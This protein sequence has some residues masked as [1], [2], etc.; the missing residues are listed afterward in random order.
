MGEL[1]EFLEQFRAQTACPECNGA[2]L[3]A[4]ARSVRVGRLG[5]HEVVD[6]TPEAALE[7]LAG[8]DLPGRTGV[9]AENIL[10]EITARLSFLV[11][12]GLSYLQLSRRSDTLSGGEAQRIRLAAQLGSHLRGV[13]YILDEPTIGLHVR[14]NQVLLDTLRRLQHAGNSVVI[15]EHDEE[16]IRQADYVIDLG[17]GGGTQGGEV[18]AVGSPAEIQASPDSLTGKFLRRRMR[19]PSRPARPLTEC[20][21]VT[22]RGAREHNLKS[23]QVRFPV[24]RLT[25]VTGVS[26]SGKSTLVRD[27]LYRAVRRQ[28][29]GMGG[30]IGEHRG[31]VGAE[32]FDRVFEVDQTPIGKTPRSIP[33]SYV[34]FFDEIRKLFSSTPEARMLGYSPGRF[35]FNI[36]GGRCEQC[37][38][39]GRIK[40]EM[41]FL[42]NVYV[43]CET[44]D[45]RRYTEET[46]SVTYRDKNIHQ[47]LE[48][49]LAEAAELFR[50]V[51][52]INRPLEIL[53]DIGLGYLTLGQPSNTLSGG[54]A[55]RIKLAYELAK[56]SRGATLYVLDEPTTGL[57][58]AD[59]EKLMRSLQ[60]LV[61]QGNTVVVIEHN[62]E[63]IREADCVVDLGPDGGERGGRVVAWGSPTELVRASERSYTARFLKEHLKAY[64][65]PVSA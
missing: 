32:V 54:E 48:M 42:P 62:L 57:H 46:L 65:V 20:G 3:N 45:G 5:I 31:I 36:K 39:Q 18:V 6:L 47:V 28:L 12:V 41:S 43:H 30:R 26:G 7:F 49:T 56:R 21:F 52:S 8:A 9:I 4:I 25:V 16:T 29:T 22:I 64:P 17:P 58:M 59:I 61:D 10:K 1:H 37:A 19:L 44:C 27:I 24:G 40:M 63:V 13:C 53:N 14:D 38:G 50:P 2:R 23:I 34:G 60:S 55:Q 33:A 15:V 35:S 11:E 51:E